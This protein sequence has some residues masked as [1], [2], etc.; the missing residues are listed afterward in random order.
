MNLHT[1]IRFLQGCAAIM[2]A[3]L[4]FQH[5]TQLGDHAIS[6]PA[7]SDF[8]KFYLSAQRL[9]KGVSMY[10]L[11]PPRERQG[12]ACHP[13]TPD[14]ERATAMPLPGRLT[15]GGELPCLSPNLNPPIFMAVM[16]PLSLL[17]YGNAWWIWAA[18]SSICSVL[19]VWLLSGSKPRTNKDR[20]FWT[21]LGS[22]ALFT[23][24]PTIANFS[25]GQL[26]S[27]LLPLL[28]MS[29]L[30]LRQARPVRSGLWL[31]LAIGLKP[32]LGVLL[33]GLF[34]L[35]NWKAMFSAIAA[36][37]GLSA[38]GALAFGVN[39]YQDY[40]LV[41]GN[42]NWTAS[43]WNG[44]WFGFFDRYFSGQANA[45]WPADKPLS[46]A[47]GT[48]FALLTA[49]LWAWITRGQQQRAATSG[50]DTLFAL[51]LPAALLASPLGWAYYF[52]VL[53]LSGFIAWQHTSH[54]V[55]PRPLRLTLLLPVVMSVV[56]ISLKPSPSTLSPALWY[57]MD[58]WY[59]YALITAMIAVAI[60]LR[61]RSSRS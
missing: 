30:D 9:H 44:S 3:A 53:T 57:G 23:Y 11:V 4:L 61:E 49:G 46:K 48:A 17:P 13:D 24:Y 31:G 43:N 21:L 33:L 59:F 51:G 41:A 2:A 42:V 45:N 12:D 29:W 38:L 40:A 10:W 1:L 27:V 37:L 22:A 18:F 19:G 39:A 56:P 60:A 5:Y 50:V 55:N 14:A 6:R 32:F 36:L 34:V 8:Y 26:G 20:L 7:S 52:P 15:L 47:L 16:L 35:R 54:A 28:T 25:L 58:A